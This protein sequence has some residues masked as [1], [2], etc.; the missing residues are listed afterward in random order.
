MIMIVILNML[1]A[2]MGDAFDQAKE[3]EV[4]NR[5][6]TQLEIMCAYVDLT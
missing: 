1:I 5:K 3:S 6:R 2:I 4:N